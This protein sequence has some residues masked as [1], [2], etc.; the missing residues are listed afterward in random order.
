ML[1]VPQ[2]GLYDHEGLASISIIFSREQGGRDGFIVGHVICE[3]L[4]GQRSL[5]TL[6][7]TRTWEGANRV[8]LRCLW[9]AHMPSAPLHVGWWRLRS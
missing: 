7:G 3:V 4:M 8:T 6:A 5:E 1:A 2:C 9:R